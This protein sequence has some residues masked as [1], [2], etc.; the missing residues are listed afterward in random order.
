MLCG[1]TRYTLTPH[2]EYSEPDYLQSYTMALIGIRRWEEIIEK[3]FN[4]KI[5]LKIEK[6]LH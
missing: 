5:L 4:I 2:Y 6:L 1:R 3:R